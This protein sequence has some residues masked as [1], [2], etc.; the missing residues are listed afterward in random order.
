MYGNGWPGPTA[1]GVSTGKISLSKTRS[2][3][4]SSS[5]SRSSISAT[6]IPAA[7]SPG[8]RWRFQ[9]F[10]CSAASA[11]ERSRISASAACGVSPSGERTV[12]PAATWSISPATRTMKNSSMFEEKI[13]QKLTRSSSGSE[14]SRTTS[15]TRPLKSSCDSSRFRNLGCASAVLTA[16]TAY[17]RLRPR[18]V[19]Y[20]LGYGGSAELCERLLVGRDHLARASGANCSFAPKLLAGPDRVGDEVAQ[21]LRL[22]RASSG[23]SRR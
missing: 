22:A 10:A 4:S 9:S 21:R 13:E 18:A 2:S 3:S 11:V 12:T 17:L 5:G 16:T 15:S 14:S 8:R 7:S 19:G 20:E 1:S 23:R 6:T